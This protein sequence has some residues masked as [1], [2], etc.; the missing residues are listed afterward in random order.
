MCDAAAAT[1]APQKM[2]QSYENCGLESIRQIINYVNGSD[3]GELEFMEWA[4]TGA[5]QSE[6][7]SNI[8]YRF[9]ERVKD[10]VSGAVDLRKSGCTTDRGQALM[11]E[12][13]GVPTESLDQ[14]AD[15]IIQAVADGKGVTTSH[16][17]SG[18]LNVP[19][20]GTHAVTVT[21]IEFDAE[22]NPTNVI[23][24]ESGRGAC[25]Q[26]IPYGQFM[27]SLDTTGKMVSTADAIW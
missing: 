13:K 20:E 18:L 8:Y 23:I 2:K 16:H 5:Y 15:N 24:N 10:P 27:G 12:V 26:S 11:M 17:V 14:T 9:A 6:E 22:G 25:S 1:R 7:G 19:Q 4:F 21:G 3:I